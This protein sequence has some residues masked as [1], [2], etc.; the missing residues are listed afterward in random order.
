M[1]PQA[2][3]AVAATRPM[4]AEAAARAEA[5]AEYW[6]L[7]GA[8]LTA[9]HLYR[10]ALDEQGRR[11]GVRLRSGG[12]QE[13]AVTSEGG[14]SAA[15]LLEELAASRG[16]C[17]RGCGGALRVRH[18][19]PAG[20]DAEVAEVHFLCGACGTPACHRIGRAELERALLP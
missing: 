7:I 16:L 10:Q 19:G 9:A 18:Y 12:G 5:W 15:G 3:R 14:R 17:C 20:S 2:P 11:R 13:P 8:I 1:R 4:R 6:D